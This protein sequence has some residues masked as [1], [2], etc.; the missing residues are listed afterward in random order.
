MN[1]II[2]IVILLFVVSCDQFEQE[3]NLAESKEEKSPRADWVEHSLQPFGMEVVLKV[4][5]AVSDDVEIRRND[6]F[7]RIEFSAGESIDFIISGEYE[8]FSARKRNL[9]SGIF[10]IEYVEDHPD[11]ILYKAMLPDGSSEYFNFVKEIN[12]KGELHAVENNPLAE[13]SEEEIRLMAEIVETFEV[14]EQLS[15]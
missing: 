10:S 7:G 1:K 6:N 11:F 4:P 2:S 9:E 3:Q 15:D 14:K 12:Y 5:E 13:F 8:P